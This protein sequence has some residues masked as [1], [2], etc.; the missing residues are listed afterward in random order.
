MICD[1]RVN[2][3]TCMLRRSN[4]TSKQQVPVLGWCVQTTTA[5][6]DANTNYKHCSA[7]GEFCRKPSNPMDWK[8][9]TEYK[10]GKFSKINRLRWESEWK[11]NTGTCENFFVYTI[12]S[13]TQHIRRSGAMRTTETTKTNSNKPSMY[14]CKTIPVHFSWTT[15]IRWCT[16]HVY[17]WRWNRENVLIFY[18][19]RNTEIYIKYYVR[20]CDSRH[21]IS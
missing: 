12:Q 16:L 15:Y 20:R 14:L 4:T 18:V 13:H 6:R 17:A 10:N 21:L 1:A 9:S 2:L 3:T 11:A 8:S 19:Q 7:T 5:T